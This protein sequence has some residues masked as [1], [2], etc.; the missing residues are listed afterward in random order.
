M[1]Y[2]LTFTLL[3]GLLYS[4]PYEEGEYVSE[5]HQ[6]ITMTTCYAGND[7]QVDDV[8]KLADWNGDL[9]GGQYNIIYVEMAASW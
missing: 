2:L 7:Y 1:R 8:W 3:L 4:I 6:N 9:N 5:E